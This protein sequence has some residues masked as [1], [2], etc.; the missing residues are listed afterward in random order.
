MTVGILSAIHL[1]S[2]GSMNKWKTQN[3]KP[4]TSEA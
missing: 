4:K 3:K 1:V 2:G